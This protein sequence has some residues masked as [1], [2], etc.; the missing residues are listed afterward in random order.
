MDAIVTI[1]YRIPNVC[2]PEDLENTGTTFNEV[3]QLIL[4]DE[5]MIGSRDVDGELLGVEPC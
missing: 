4:E 5:G 1:K 2:N 3:V